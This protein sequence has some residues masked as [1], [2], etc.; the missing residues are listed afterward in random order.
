M[1]DQPTFTRIPN[2]IIEAMPTLGNGELRVLLAIARKTYGWQKECD[3]ISVSQ[4]AA[5]TGLTSRNAQN[6]I[7]AL[8]E[9]GLIARESAGKQRYCYTLKTIS[10]RDT[11]ENHIPTDTVSLRDTEPYP[12]GIQL[13]VKPYPLGITQKKDLKEKKER[14]S[15]RASSAP[16]TPP[17]PKQ[18]N[19]DTFNQAVLIYKELSEKKHVQAAITSLIVDQVCELDRWRATIQ[20]W[21]GSGFNPANVSGMLDWYAH[22]EKMAAKLA[23]HGSKSSPPPMKSSGPVVTSKPNIAPD[24]LSPAERAE[25][26]KAY[27]N[28][29]SRTSTE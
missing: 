24:A 28:A 11:V 23:Q 10:P 3:V 5:M 29:S 6:A 16:R 13:E 14:E 1:A 26:I 21:L 27:F 8:L 20:A 17:L 12:L 22:P 18:T 9:K 2:D 25:M 19:L 7:V 4:I 15:V